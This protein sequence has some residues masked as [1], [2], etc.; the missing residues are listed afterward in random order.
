MYYPQ[1][2]GRAELAIKT[3][4]RILIDSI[5][6]YGW[7]CYDLAA[8][9]LLTRCNTSIQGL[10]MSPAMMLYNRVIKDHLPA[11]RDKYRIH[12][13]WNEISRYREKVMAKRHLRNERQYEHSHLLQEIE[14]SQPV[15]IQYQPDPYPH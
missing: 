4:K 3:A 7:L 2:N 9:A 5:D 1:S 12:K 15:Q 11:L 14:V 6:V 13:R 10:D 8:R